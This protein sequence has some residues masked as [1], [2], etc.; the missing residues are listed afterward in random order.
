MPVPKRGELL[1]RLNM[2]GELARALT[3]R[4]MP[5]DQPPHTGAGLC[6]SDI[7][8][9]K[10]DLGAPMTCQTSG[11]EGAGVVVALGEGVEDW[12]V[13]DRGGVKPIWDTCHQC[14]F[15]REGM[16]THCAKIKPTGVVVDGSYSQVSWAS[17]ELG[18]FGRRG[19]VARPKR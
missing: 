16:E 14:S 5:F 3:R 7:H 19:V 2:T 15:C 8:G 1:L 9:M 10:C 4:C 18:G 17:A 13:G 6:L 11:H 12:Q